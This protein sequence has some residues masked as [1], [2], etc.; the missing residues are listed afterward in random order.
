MCPTL[1][2]TG[3]KTAMIGVKYGHDWDLNK[4]HDWV[5]DRHY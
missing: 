1:L 4:S 2:A 5:E 3:L